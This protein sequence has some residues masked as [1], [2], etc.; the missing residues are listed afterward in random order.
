MSFHDL[1][2]KPTTPERFLLRPQERRRAITVVCA[3][4]CLTEG[5]NS[6]NYV[7]RLQSSL[8]TQGFTFINA[9]VAGDLAF[10]LL[11]RL[12]AVIA[13]DPDVV[14]LLIGTN[15]VAA[16]IDSEWRDAYTREKQLP[17]EPSFEFFAA[18]VKQI[19]NRLEAETSAAII[20]IEMPIMG[21]DLAT[22]H[23]RR[24]RAY[25]AAVR[26][27]A[28]ER[29]LE[30]LPFHRRMVRSLAQAGAP[31]PFDGSTQLMTRAFLNRYIRRLSWNE[32]SE[33]NGLDLLTDNLHLNDRSALQL[34]DLISSALLTPPRNAGGQP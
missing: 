13:C 25:N 8:G 22:E 33:T 7:S 23:N 12:E 30:V 15:D 16:H 19:F 9:G 1:I 31:T 34:T 11:Q 18:S 5:I 27:M 32:I 24:V 3:G 6:S 28:H 17:E 4:D 2:I 10:N 26:Q 14:T 21:E 29:G 20:P